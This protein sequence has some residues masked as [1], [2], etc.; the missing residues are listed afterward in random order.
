MK[1]EYNGGTYETEP[2]GE[3][4]VCN[5]C[6]KKMPENWIFEVV[7]VVRYATNQLPQ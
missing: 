5:N 2:S 6:G 1:V 7:R 4:Y 3:S